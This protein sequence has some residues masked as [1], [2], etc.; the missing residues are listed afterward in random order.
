MCTP[1]SGELKRPPKKRYS[2]IWDASKV[3]SYLK[4]LPSVENLSLKLLTYKL[5][6]LIALTQA[7]RCQSLQLLSLKDV[8]QDLSQG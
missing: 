3:L 4:T 8:K 5:A 1:C 2:V 6:V 7:N